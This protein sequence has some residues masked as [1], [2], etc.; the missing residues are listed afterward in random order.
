MFHK[1]SLEKN[2]LKHRETDS[3]RKLVKSQGSDAGLHF[4]TMEKR[5]K[6][7]GDGHKGWQ[8]MREMGAKENN[9]SGNRSAGPVYALHPVV[10]QYEERG[11]A[12]ETGEGS[13]A[14]GEARSCARFLR[15]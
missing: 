4:V 12:R 8:Y 6:G 14:G 11:V 13:G 1:G 10:V 15:V 5:N 2:K 3:E 9:G 7:L